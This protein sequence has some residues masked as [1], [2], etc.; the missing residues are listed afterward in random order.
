MS[1]TPVSDVQ[2]TTE[3]PPVEKVAKAKVKAAGNFI[4][5]TATEIETLTK[6]KALNYADKL[7]EDIDN[8]SFKLGGCLKVI[9]DNGWFEGAESFGEFVANRFGFQERKAR[10]LMEIYENLVS[11]QIPWE[12]VQI[13]GWSK[14]K[15]LAKHLTPENVDEWVAKAQ[16]VTVTELQ[17]MLK[18]TASDSPDKT[19]SD[20]TTLKFKFKNDQLE[21]VQ[22]ALSKAKA[23]TNT[24][25]DNVAIENICAGYLGGTVAAAKGADLKT[26]MQGAG[27]EAVLGIF[28]ELFPKVD[29]TVSVQDG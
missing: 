11:K 6:T 2:A 5:D 8:N 19:T 24:E 12:K 21:T 4:M 20:T 17:A 13:L 27:W 16:N 7:A 29:L 18:A 23:E 25:F 28:G 15:D 22:S 1:E 9:L 10:Y 3:A 14:L 26:Q